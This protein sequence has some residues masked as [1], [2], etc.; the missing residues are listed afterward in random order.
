[1]SRMM[2]KI[3]WHRTENP[4]LNFEG[5]PSTNVIRGSVESDSIVELAQHFADTVRRLEE[6]EG[7]SITYVSIEFANQ[8]DNI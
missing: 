3:R 4:P 6:K 7:T 1:M 2:F 8:D 5:K